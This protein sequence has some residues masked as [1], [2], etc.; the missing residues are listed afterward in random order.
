[1][2]RETT[3][4]HKSVQRNSDFIFPYA[5]VYVFKYTSELI[6]CAE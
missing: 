5:S 4:P 2:Y 1:M 6:L 3:E